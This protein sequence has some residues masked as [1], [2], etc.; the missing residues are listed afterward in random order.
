M[1]FWVKFK[2]GNFVT[3]HLSPCF[4]VIQIDWLINPNSWIITIHSVY[5]FGTCQSSESFSPLEVSAGL[6]TRGSTASLFYIEVS[7]SQFPFISL[8]ACH[9]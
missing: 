2:A 4:I 6:I 7:A 1:N 8:S 3:I 9:T 5:L